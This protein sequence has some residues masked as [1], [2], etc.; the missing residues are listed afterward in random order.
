MNLPFTINSK[1]TKGKGIGAEINFPTINCHID[2]DIEIGLYASSIRCPFF[3]WKENSISCVSILE[4]GRTR[5]ETH[6]LESNPCVCNVGE[7]VELTLY[8]K[9]REYVKIDKNNRQEIID[10]DKLAGEKFFAAPPKCESCKFFMMEDYGYSNWTVEGT[11]YSCLKGCFGQTEDR[12]ITF[13]QK[14]CVKHGEGDPWCI[15]VDH[16]SELPTKE[17]LAENECKY[18]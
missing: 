13:A 12:D 16:E 4:S 11:N 10:S 15:D 17:W 1:R 2:D 7:D 3:S 6:I 8:H 5:I 14:D 9:L 18:E